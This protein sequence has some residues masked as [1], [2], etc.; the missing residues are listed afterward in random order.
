MVTVASTYRQLPLDSPSAHR[1]TTSYV[2]L[3]SA[4][5]GARVIRASDEFFA[6][7]EN[8]IKVEVSSLSPAPAWFVFLASFAGALL[9]LCDASRS[10][11]AFFLFRWGW[12]RR[13]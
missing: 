11:C 6:E 7:K 4:A 10:S 3:S 8:L 1:L 12:G 13:L 9:V 5:L 2:E